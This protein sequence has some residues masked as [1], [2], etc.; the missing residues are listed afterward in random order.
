MILGGANHGFSNSI[1]IAVGFVKAESRPVTS[2]C[3]CK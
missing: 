3:L 2:S 1:W